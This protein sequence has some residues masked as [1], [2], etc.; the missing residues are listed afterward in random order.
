VREVR[1]RTY[2]GH[3][4]IEVSDWICVKKILPQANKPVLVAVEFE[5]PA[6][7]PGFIG[8][9]MLAKRTKTHPEPRWKNDYRIAGGFMRWQSVTHWKPLPEFP[10]WPKHV[11]EPEKP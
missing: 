6:Y 4:D 3:K 8:I 5:Q 2:T 7:L 9:A 10:E 11:S 1:R